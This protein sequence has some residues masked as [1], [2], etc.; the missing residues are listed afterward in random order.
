V[1]S[2]C[3]AFNFDGIYF[4][5]YNGASCDDKKCAQGSYTSNVNSPGQCS[6]GE[7]SV[8]RPMT[9]YTVPNTRDR[10][11]YYVYV[12][13]GR[14]SGD[15][16]TGDFRLFVQ[17]GEGGKGGTGGSAAIK[18]APPGS[19]TSDGGGDGGSNN[20]GG[21]GDGGNGSGNNKSGANTASTCGHHAWV[22][23]GIVSAMLSLWL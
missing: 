6:F 10:D 20:N 3:G 23:G 17:D 19:S 13:W 8:S 12:H 16:P 22:V 4:S 2:A 15:K 11:R 9:Q 5:V 14:T 21:G 1:I 18:F 7:A